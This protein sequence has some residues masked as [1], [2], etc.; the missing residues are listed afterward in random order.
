MYSFLVNSSEIVNFQCRYT[1]TGAKS[2]TAATVYYLYL[3]LSQ[4]LGYNG[5]QQHT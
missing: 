1:V 4:V 3:P 2:R 5:K